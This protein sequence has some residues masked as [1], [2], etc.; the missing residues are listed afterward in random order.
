VSASEGAREPLVLR[1][2]TLEDADL[3]L[4]WANDPVTRAAGFNPAPIGLEEHRRW[5]SRRLA[6]PATRLF[7]GL[8]D[9]RPV[10]QLRLERGADGLAEI[11]IAIAPEAR[12]RGLGRRLL[13]GGIDAARA[14][15]ALAVA[16]FIARVRPD[17]AGSLALFR[18]AGFVD[19]HR[20]RVGN[21]DCLV[22]KLA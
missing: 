2:A 17:N 16:G 6:S 3:L 8:L 7:V 14:D 13:R 20:T 19:S 11:S 18:G 15:P 21:F 4:A 22:L 12:G 9:G 1:P 10:G 5:L